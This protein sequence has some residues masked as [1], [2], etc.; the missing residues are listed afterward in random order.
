MSTIS[1]P[2][3]TQTPIHELLANRF[4]PRVFDPTH[5]IS[6]AEVLSLAEAA[7]WAPSGNNAQPWRFGFAKRSDELFAKVSQSGL[8]GFNQSWAPQSSL[9]VF[10]LANKSKADGTEIERH[11]SYFNNALATSQIVLQA[12]S[13]GLKAH[14]MGGVLHDVILELLGVDD[15]WLTCVIAIGKQGDV[16]LVSEELQLREKA[17]RERKP[18]SE[19][20]I[21]LS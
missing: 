8:T 18:L 5:E 20:V 9:Y 19:I 14:Y 16:D 13:L 7:R 2:A 3:Q 17:A 1:K 15:A 10:A 12:E 21:A 6:D 11:G 4:S